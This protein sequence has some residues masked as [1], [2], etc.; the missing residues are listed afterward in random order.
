MRV[1]TSLKISCEQVSLPA[2]AIVY[3]LKELG[4]ASLAFLDAHVVG[5]FTQRVAMHRPN[6]QTNRH[7]LLLL[8]GNLLWGRLYQHAVYKSHPHLELEVYAYLALA[9]V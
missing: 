9:D 5:A 6:K 3:E 8:R 1:L 7:Q 4:R 2:C